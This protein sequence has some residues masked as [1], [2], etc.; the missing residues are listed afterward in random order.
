MAMDEESLRR[1]QQAVILCGGLGRR[2]LPY[3]KTIP[4]PMVPCNGKPFLWYLF[5]QFEEQG[6][7]RFILLTGY[8][9]GQIEDYFGDGQSWGWQIQ[10]SQGP[11]EWDTGKRIWEAKEKIDDRFLLLYSDNF[12][13]FP[14]D[15]VFA[16][17]EQNRL[18]LTFM[19]S[20]KSP[21]N[22]ALDGA[23]TVQNYDNNR[24]TDLGYVE[25]GYMIVE[26]EKTL[27]FFE[28][29]E[30]SFSSILQKMAAKQQISAWVQN[31]AYHS[32]SD[33]ERWKK[34]ETYLKPKKILLIDRDGVI[35]QKAVRGE[36]VSKWEN[37]EWITETRKAMKE[38]TQEGFQ[39]IV[40]TNQAGIARGMIDPGELKRIHQN[41]RKELQKDGIQILDIFFCPHHWDEKCFCRKPNPGMLFQASKE[42]LFRLDKTIFIG[43]DPRDCQTAWRAGCFSV[44]L[45]D[46]SELKNFKDDDQPEFI[47]SGLANSLDFIRNFFHQSS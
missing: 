8:L 25:I 32:I 5:Q 34:T 12:V 13:P 21:G 41:M 45:G 10:Y 47:A 33:P 22:I 36:Y 46:K 28:I 16:L 42:H 9:A 44:F 4:K 37:F 17:H 35:N 14:I 2:M 20:Q 30:C 26:K 29:P 7:K 19:V 3:T 31:D 1:P 38:L 23:G 15:K 18:P 11:V 27:G 39:F 24:S 6:I 43:D 40:I